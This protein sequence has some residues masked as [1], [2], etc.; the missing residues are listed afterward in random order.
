MIITRKF[1]KSKIQ[2]V[3]LYFIESFTRFFFK[4]SQGVGQSPT[5]FIERRNLDASFK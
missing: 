2:C 3:A 4:K 1:F 5:V